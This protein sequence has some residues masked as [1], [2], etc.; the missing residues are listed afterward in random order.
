MYN[1][2]LESNEPESTRKL[3]W[4]A[5]TESRVLEKSKPRSNHG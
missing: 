4:T 3:C 5:S 2:F 1:W